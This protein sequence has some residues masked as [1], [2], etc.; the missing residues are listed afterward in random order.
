MEG[1]MLKV[2]LQYFGQLMRRANSLQKTLR[3]G[4][5]GG[6]MRRGSN[7]SDNIIDLMDMNLGELQEIVEDRR[8]WC[9]H[10][11]TMSWT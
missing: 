5:T 10:G 9:V 3:L 7:W 4:K 8:A 11:F 2:K 1:L 6:K